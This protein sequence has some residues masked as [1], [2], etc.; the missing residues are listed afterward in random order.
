MNVCYISDFGKFKIFL[1]I[2][3]EELWMLR[4]A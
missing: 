2:Q 1:I 3:N 4:I